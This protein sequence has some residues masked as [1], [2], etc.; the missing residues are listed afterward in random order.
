MSTSERTLLSHTRVGTGH[1]VLFVHGWLTGGELWDSTV[2]ALGGAD[3]PLDCVLPDLRGSAGTGGVPDETLESHVADLVALLDDLKLD[4]VSVVG[5]SMGG[6]VS[7]LLAVRH[8]NRVK[9]LV[10]LASVPP[11]GFPLPEDVFA[12]FDAAGGDE[13]ALRSFFEPQVPEAHVGP[14]A[15]LAARTNREAARA[16]LRAWTGTS[17]VEEARAIDKPCLVLAG[18][19]DPFL[20]PNVLEG[21]IVDVIPGARLGVVEAGH[22]PQVE[23][24]GDVAERV[25][26]ELS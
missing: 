6:A 22:Y 19:N 5:H 25:R 2:E 20:G 4:T 26:D 21:A 9:R 7:T 23:K 15:A 11:S 17:F 13:A 24:P 8:P 12:S 1:P 14:L 3:A 10:L 16:T 18:A